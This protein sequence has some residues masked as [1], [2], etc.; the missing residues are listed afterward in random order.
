MLNRCVEPRLNA[1]YP[2][3][4]TIEGAPDPESLAAGQ[5]PEG[6]DDRDDLRPVH[7]FNGARHT[8][9][10]QAVRFGRV[11]RTRPGMGAQDV[12]DD[13]PQPGAAG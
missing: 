11:S 1:V 5:Q 4:D 10:R 2:C 3:L 6:R 13:V 8:R 9:A 7:R 12:L